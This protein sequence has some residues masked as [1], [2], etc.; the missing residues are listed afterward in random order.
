MGCHD[1]REGIWHDEAR[2]LLHGMAAGKNCCQDLRAVVI[3]RFYA[4]RHSSRLSKT[5]LKGGDMTNVIFIHGIAILYLLN[6]LQDLF[7]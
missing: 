4:G 5:L 1:N 6:A 2:E 3:A 7:K